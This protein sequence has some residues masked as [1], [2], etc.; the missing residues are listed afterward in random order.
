[1]T[2]NV[3]GLFSL[4]AGAA[5]PG[6]GVLAGNPSIS[7]SSGL[8]NMYIIDGIS[9]TDAG[10]GAFGVFSINYGSLGTGV[11]TDFVKEVQIKTGGFEA[12]YGQAMGGIINI[13]TDSGGNKLHGSAYAYSAPG[14]AEGT[15]K[16]PNDFPRI[17]SPGTETIGRHSWDAGFNV[18]GPFI[19]NKFFW[20]GSFN[21]SFSSMSP[22]GAGELRHARAGSA[23]AQEQVL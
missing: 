3:S 4:A 5:P 21:P 15:Y 17:G 1:M 23:D 18:G 2:R 13:V 10:Y 12:Q 11:N 9:T 6:D 8:E 14:F 7:G 19:Q 22:A 16:Q 20:Y